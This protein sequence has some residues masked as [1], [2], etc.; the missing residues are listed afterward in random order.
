M[1]AIIFDFSGTLDNLDD[2]RLSAV[3]HALTEI[4]GDLSYEERLKEAKEV[5]VEIFRLDLEMQSASIKDIFYKA[6]FLKYGYTISDKMEKLWQIY[7]SYRQTHRGLLESFVNNFP[8]ISKYKLF[9][10]TRSKE[11]T[12][13]E[14]L[15]KYNIEEH[16]QIYRTRKPST[17]TL[18]LIMYEHS[19][20]PE[21]C[22]MVGDD[23]ILDLMPAKM[24]GMKTILRSG[25]VDYFI[26]D[27]NNIDGFI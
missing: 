9:I 2:V 4:R 27:F 11:E 21:E 6:L 18:T 19:L 15:K 7:Y 25:Y 13:R 17:E 16:F 20:K 26:P 24:L 5:I 22:I 23:V 8:L 1:K 3:E 12:I 10:L 14:L